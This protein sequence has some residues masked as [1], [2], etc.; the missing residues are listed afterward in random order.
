M[1][2]AQI[3]RGGFTQRRGEKKSKSSGWSELWKNVEI[4]APKQGRSLDVYG[5]EMV[6]F[7]AST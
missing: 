2:K 4:A 7:V 1:L 6:D 5:S 3:Y